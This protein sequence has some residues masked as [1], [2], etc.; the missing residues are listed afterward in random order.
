MGLR[1]L[2]P[3]LKGRN[4]AVITRFLAIAIPFRTHRHKNLRML[5]LFSVHHAI[6]MSI[7]S[8]S[9]STS[10]L[11]QVKAELQ[12]VGLSLREAGCG[13]V[14]ATCGESA[15]PVNNGF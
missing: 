7:A 13:V 10:F 12:A 4:G 1:I 15:E 2:A 8:Q 9:V 3:G 14:N 5:Q 6:R 11:R